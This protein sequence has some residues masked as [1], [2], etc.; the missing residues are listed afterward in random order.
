MQ[1]AGVAASEHL[2]AY[3]EQLFLA[4][5]FVGFHLVVD[6]VGIT[7]HFEV[8]HF[9]CAVLVVGEVHGCG[10]YE[11]VLDFLDFLFWYWFVAQA[12][13]FFP[14]G[15]FGCV[16]VNTF[17]RHA[18]NDELSGVDAARDVGIE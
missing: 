15:L 12:V 2:T 18:G 4:D 14:Y 17:G 9:G 8:C 3:S 10:R 6:V 16:D 5:I 1:D 11:L 13:E 7:E